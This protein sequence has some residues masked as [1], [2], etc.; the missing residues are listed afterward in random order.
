MLTQHPMTPCPILFVGLGVC[1]VYVC[2]GTACYH[3][4]HA[5]IEDQILVYTCVPLYLALWLSM[6]VFMLYLQ[7]TEPEGRKLPKGRLKASVLVLVRST[8]AF[9][10]SSICVDSGIYHCVD[11][12]RVVHGV[13]RCTLLSPLSY[14]LYWL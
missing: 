11:L 2:L 7:A 6:F 9:V 12:C 5:K 8:V 13:G 3:V 10:A 4:R 14:C 1:Y